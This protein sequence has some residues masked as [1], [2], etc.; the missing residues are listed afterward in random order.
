MRTLLSAAAYARLSMTVVKA[1][2][3]TEL[4][5]GTLEDGYFGEVSQ[6]DLINH[7]DLFQEANLINIGSYAGSASTTWLKITVAGKLLYISKAS[8]RTNVSWNTLN[9]RKLIDGSK[10]LFIKD[11]KF[12]LRT[13]TGSNATQPQVPGG[14]FNKTILKLMAAPNGDGQFA[15]M[16]SSDLF[17]SAAFN[18]C[19]EVQFSNTANNVLRTVPANAAITYVTRAT[20]HAS[21]GWRPVLEWVS[22]KDAAI[23]PELVPYSVTNLGFTSNLGGSVNDQFYT[24]KEVGYASAQLLTP[25]SF[26]GATEDQFYTNKE[27]SYTADTSNAVYGLVGTAIVA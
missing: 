19:Q 13:L 20:F 21:Y 6:E 1:P 25:F 15:S 4:L 17:G 9:D 24:N 22:P 16:P 26:V 7:T 2:G 12:K 11:F 27:V 23:D 14:E 8:L 3:P 10:E 5:A 18:I